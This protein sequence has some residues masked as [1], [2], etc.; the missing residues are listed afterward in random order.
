MAILTENNARTFKIN[1]TCE[2][3]AAADRAAL[4][5]V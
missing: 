3:R 1:R 2:L 5:S 4:K